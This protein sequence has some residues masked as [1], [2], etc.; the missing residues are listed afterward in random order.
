MYIN[1]YIHTLTLTYTLL[2]SFIWSYY[3]FFATQDQR[4]VEAGFGGG[5]SGSMGGAESGWGKE[6]AGFV[7][8]ACN[9][10]D[11]R[12]IFS[13]NLMHFFPSILYISFPRSYVFLVLDPLRQGLDGV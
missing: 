1:T 5:V 11:H 13:L 2:C 7:V 6:G 10:D 4:R 3:F 8:R 12:D 9:E